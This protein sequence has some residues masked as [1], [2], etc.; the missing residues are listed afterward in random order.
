MNTIMT[1][2]EWYTLR[3]LAHILGISYAKTR[4]TVDVLSN[5]KIIKTREKPGDNRI[6]QVHNE[7]LDLVRQAAGIVE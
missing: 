7:S 3:E 4:Y 1:G 2:Q 6:L 5:I